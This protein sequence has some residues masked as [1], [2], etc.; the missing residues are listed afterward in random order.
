MAQSPS[1]KNGINDGSPKK[2][3]PL[4]LSIGKIRKPHGVRGELLVEVLTEFPERIKP[5][6]KVFIGENKIEQQIETVRFQ[7]DALLIKFK[8][9]QDRDEA[10][11]LRNELIFIQAANLPK[12][13]ENEYYYHDLLNMQV[14]TE[15]GELLGS[16]NDILETGANE[17]LVVTQEGKEYLFPFI[18]QVI[19]AVNK[20]DN[21]ILIKKQE[22]K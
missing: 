21:V 4:F 18:K 1:N 6:K 2:G 22:W 12:L 8:G 11:L 19:V 14:K 10:G 3:E 17:V 16:V 7:N 13:A 9:I 15:E 20:E 5:E